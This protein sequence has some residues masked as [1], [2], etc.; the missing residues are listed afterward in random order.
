MIDA[1]TD[2]SN[3]SQ[4]VVVLRYVFD[5]CEDLIG[6]YRMLST[7]AATLVTTA[8]DALKDS[9][10]PISKLHGQCCCRYERSKIWSSQENS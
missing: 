6:L 3:A 10:L 4:A 7:D 5:V 9:G 1:M 8:K 2:V